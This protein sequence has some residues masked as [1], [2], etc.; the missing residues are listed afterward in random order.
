MFLYIRFLDHPYRA[1]EIAARSPT[2]HTPSRLACTGIT[3]IPLCSLLELARSHLPGRVFPPEFGQMSQ[4]MIGFHRMCWR[5][6]KSKFASWYQVTQ[7]LHHTK[8]EDQQQEVRR[9]VG[10]IA[11][12]L[13]DG[14][15]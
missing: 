7:R 13:M 4:N 3:D 5:S 8:K 10:T 6:R 11:E 1:A 9:Q 15:E 2:L 14:L 12:S